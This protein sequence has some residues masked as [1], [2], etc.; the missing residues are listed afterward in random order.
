MFALATCTLIGLTPL[1]PWNNG[2][3]LT[4]ALSYDPTIRLRSFESLEPQERWLELIEVYELPLDPAWRDTALRV[5]S[6]RLTT[7]FPTESAN[8]RERSGAIERRAREVKSI[9]VRER[10][11]ERGNEEIARKRAR[12]LEDL[13]AS[14]DKPMPVTVIRAWDGIAKAEVVLTFGRGQREV[15]DAFA[16]G[17][18]L[19]AEIGLSS[20]GEDFQA[21][22]ITAE[23]VISPAS[24]PSD[25]AMAADAPPTSHSIAFGELD[26]SAV[27]SPVVIR[28][29]KD[30]TPGSGVLSLQLELA[31]ASLAIDPRY[32]WFTEFRLYELAKDGTRSREV[33]PIGSNVLVA[34]GS[35]TNL[36]GHDSERGDPLALHSIAFAVG[37][38]EVNQP[39]PW[40]Y[41][42]EIVRWFGVAPK[43]MLKSS[44]KSS[45]RNSQSRAFD[46]AA[47]QDSPTTD[48]PLPEP[49]TPEIPDA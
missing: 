41:E 8:L 36:S 12:L 1:A 6:D 26:T 44:M 3:L 2:A 32:P 28:A 5:S 37:R 47:S 21:I 13:A 40:G 33:K 35:R 27:T 16:V 30:P 14:A 18:P 43:S 9:K 25:F 38:V 11:Y 42:A 34:L 7:Y 20:P 22:R 19:L 17:R 10:I 4:W 39:Q 15:V 23:S 31:S 29:F 48:D 49:T 45:N 46:S 24:A